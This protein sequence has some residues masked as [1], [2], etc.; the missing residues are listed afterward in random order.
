[1]KNLTFLF[2]G[3]V[4]VAAAL[5]AGEQTLVVTPQTLDGWT[6]TAADPSGLS[7]AS[8]LAL[9]G[10]AQLSRLFDSDVVT[11]R[12][13]T[14]V[15]FGLAGEDFSTL[16]VGPAALVFSR[17]GMAGQIVLVMG[18]NRS[19]PLPF[20]V[21]LNL[22]GSSI[23]PVEVQLTYDRASGNVIVTGFGQTLSYAT[24]PSP[25][26]VEV[27]ISA[28]THEAFTLQNLTVQLLTTDDPATR[29]TNGATG[30]PS[31]T[32]TN[33]HLTASGK[34]NLS[35]SLGSGGGALTTTD[36]GLAAKPSA[37]AGNMTLE[38]YTPAAVRHGH[39]DAIRS[40]V[41][42]GKKL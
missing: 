15:V 21:K 7:Q 18:D 9:P 13:A 30:L 27:V 40:A 32:S 19:Y 23:D 17:E 4:L 22:D 33:T 31:A 11:L 10:G 39:V 37:A 20:P 8:M 1:M 29:S 2:L 34:R 26:P 12:L 16:E 42:H 25:K 6:V 38:V 41:A 5:Q 24:E 35:G 28:G 36:S 14:P 3:S